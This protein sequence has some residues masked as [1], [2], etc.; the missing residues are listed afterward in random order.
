MESLIGHYSDAGKPIPGNLHWH[1]LAPPKA[2]I[3]TLIDGATKVNTMSFEMLTK[4]TDPNRSQHNYFVQ[5]LGVLN[6]FIDQRTGESFGAVDSWGTDRVLVIDP[7]TGLNRAV[8]SLVVGSKPVKS[9]ADWGVAQDQIERLLHYLTDSC[10]TNFVLLTHIE[11]EIDQINGGMKI[12]IATL[13]KALAPK[14]PPMF[15]DVV[16]AYR[17]GDK[18]LW[19]TL[20]SNAIVK[21]R[22]LPISDK[23]APDF[24]QIVAKW[25]ARSL[26]ASAV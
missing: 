2:N 9:P 26:S 19:S 23:L 17:E 4:M 20:N 22:N 1:Y 14:I 24:G 13:G 15:S 11:K 12:T 6:D 16:L 10:R 25:K 7:L 3:Q 8:M 5:F 18:F 21:N